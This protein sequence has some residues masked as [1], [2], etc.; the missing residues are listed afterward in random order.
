MSDITTVQAVL[1]AIRVSPRKL[2]LIAAK[3]R[4]LRV[5][6]A[7]NFLTFSSKRAA[8]DVK[9]NLL[10][11]IANAENNHNMDVDRLYVHE[12]YVGPGIKL[13]RFQ[14]RAKGRAGSIYKVF[15]HLSIKVA[16][17]EEG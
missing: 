3:I 5:D 13:K 9:K 16:E 2:N 17:K 8:K 12:A 7:L 6:K 15:S 11:A 10:S 1:G 14:A 4:G